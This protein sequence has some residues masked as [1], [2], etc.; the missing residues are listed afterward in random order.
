MGVQEGYHPDLSRAQPL[1]NV[2]G[3]WGSRARGGTSSW[4]GKAAS[5][6]K[7]PGSAFGARLFASA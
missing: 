4:I 6:V 3:T 7:K 5:D 1:D 2:V